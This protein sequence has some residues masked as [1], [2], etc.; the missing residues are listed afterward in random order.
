MRK[1][2]IVVGGDVPRT[3]IFLGKLC[4][5]PIK[6]YT[7]KMLSFHHLFVIE[8]YFL[9]CPFLELYIL[10]VNKFK[11]YDVLLREER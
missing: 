7:G 2:G 5:W 11:L 1:P 9:D 6:G 4:N 3:A 10:V 8:N